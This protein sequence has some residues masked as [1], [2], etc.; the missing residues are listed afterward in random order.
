[1]GKD[2]S[3]Q[4][5]RHT[6]NHVRGCTRVSEGCRNCYA[7]TMS[8]RN[9]AVLGVWGN[10]G[11]RVVA[12]EAKWKEPIAWNKLAAQ[13]G[14]RDRV[15]CASLADVFED[16]EGPLIDSRGRTLHYNSTAIWWLP[17]A[18]I[19]RPIPMDFVRRRL[20]L[21]IR[22]TF[23]LDWL[24]LT[25][26]IENANEMLYR[27][28]FEDASWPKNYW[29]GTTVEDRASKHRID[30]LRATPAPKRF[31]SIEP[32]IEDLG[33]LD[34]TGIDVVFVGGESGGHARPFYAEWARNIHRQCKEQDTVF[35][36]KQMGSHLLI[37]RGESYDWLEHAE[38]EVP[39]G[40]NDPW[41]VRLKDSHGGNM[42]EWPDDLRVRQMPKMEGC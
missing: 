38:C 14:E 9:P 37:H 31:L 19:H 33:R 16:W 13:S 36:M 3:I 10:N 34:L 4:W 28:W 27:M 8:K 42:S 2:S 15:F 25:K 1:M 17:D 24:L 30:T 29:L 20:A 18:P 26:R 12:S 32:L 5:T 41:R 35:F 40:R 23:H 6:F 39:S 22:E 11:T 21:T 7:E